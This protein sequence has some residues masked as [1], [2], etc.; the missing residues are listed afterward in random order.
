MY[1]HMPESSTVSNVSLCQRHAMAAPPSAATVAMERTFSQLDTAPTPM[2]AVLVG[3]APKSSRSFEPDDEN[4]AD[5]T[6]GT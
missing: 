5:W 1:M 6:V 4:R 2:P 3:C